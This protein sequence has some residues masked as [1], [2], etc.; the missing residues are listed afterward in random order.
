[1]MQNKIS[2]LICLLFGFNLQAQEFTYEASVTPV[3]EQGF[4]SI[5]LSPELL[6]KL[7]S[8]HSDLRIYD[9]DGQEQPYLLKVEP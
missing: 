8:D 1:M 9:D 5:V 7:K 6:G 2:W 4:Y 3:S